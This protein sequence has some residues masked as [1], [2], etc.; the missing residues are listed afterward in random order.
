MNQTNIIIHTHSMLLLRF[1][2]AL[3]QLMNEFFFY[4]TVIQIGRTI[5]RREDLLFGLGKG[6][7]LV[8]TVLTNLVLADLTN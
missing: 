5:R 7:C 3:L 1:S 2:V 4:S 8:F 6:V